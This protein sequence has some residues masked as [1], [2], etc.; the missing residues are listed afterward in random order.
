LS[1]RFPALHLPTLTFEHASLSSVIHG[2]IHPN[3]AHPSNHCSHTAL[4]SVIHASIHPSIH[5]NPPHPSMCALLQTRVTAYLVRSFG[6]VRVSRSHQ[7]KCSQTSTSWHLLLHHHG[8]T[9]TC[10]ALVSEI[11]CIH[12]PYLPPPTFM[13]TN[14]SFFLH[15]VVPTQ[16]PAYLPTYLPTHPH[17]NQRVFSFFFFSFLCLLF[18]SSY[19]RTYTA[20]RLPT[21]LPPPPTSQP[22]CFFLFSFFLFFVFVF[23]SSYLRTYTATCLPTYLPTYPPTHPPSYLFANQATSYQYTFMPTHTLLPTNLPTC[24]PHLSFQTTN[25]QFT[26]NPPLRS[27]IGPRAVRLTF[28]VNTAA[29]DAANVWDGQ[30]KRREDRG[31]CCAELRRTAVVCVA[32]LRCE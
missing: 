27:P 23:S 15:I 32:S 17:P 6:C 10:S 31:G 16:Q 24:L 22:T 7:S 30:D 26:S 13:A 28:V 25:L 1:N 3:L 8:E 2:S 18:S 12:F 4:T 20:T 5:P 11:S 21:Y 29:F 14:M 19:L 9:T